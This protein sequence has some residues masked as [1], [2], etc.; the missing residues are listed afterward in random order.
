M[1]TRLPV[2][3][4]LAASS[5][6]AAYAQNPTAQPDVTRQQTYT[7]H[8]ESSTDPAGANADFRVV[9]PGAT[10][11]VLDADGPGTISHLWFTIATGEPYHLKRIVLRIYWDGE[12]NPVLRHRLAISLDWAWAPTTIGSLRCFLSVVIKA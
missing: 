11:T 5:M 7:L 8:R 4:A 3:F 1:M 10:L 12:Q 6:F 2:F 9:A